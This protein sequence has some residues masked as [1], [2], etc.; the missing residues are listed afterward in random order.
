MKRATRK[1]PGGLSAKRRRFVCEY[2]VDQNAK[3]AAIRAGYS[4]RSTEV[5]ACRLLRNAKVRA[6]VEKR[7]ED[8]E[9]KADRVLAELAKIAFSNMADYLTIGP[10]GRAGIDFSKVSRDEFAGIRE[11]KICRGANRRKPSG[12]RLSLR[13]KVHALDLLAK[14]LGL[15]GGGNQ[16]GGATEMAAALNQGRLRAAALLNDGRDAVPG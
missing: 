10:G 13:H 14:Y 9:I 8:H 3:R 7:L 16:S 5:T 15:V 12:F 2:L 4:Q 11:L 1:V 6:A